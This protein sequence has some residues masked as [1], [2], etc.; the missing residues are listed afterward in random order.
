MHANP[1]DYPKPQ[2]DGPFPGFPGLALTYNDDGPLSPDDEIPTPRQDW[3]GVDPDVQERIATRVA[4][5]AAGTSEEGQKA[6]ERDALMA[7]R[8]LE[9]LG[10]L[11]LAQQKLDRLA[12]KAARAAQAA[13][14]Q[15]MPTLESLSAQ[16]QKLAPEL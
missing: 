1:S 2:P 14:E 9:M 8:T 4:A 12:E 7:A 11:V 15:E 10:N 5:L 13:K 3:G 16:A 6:S